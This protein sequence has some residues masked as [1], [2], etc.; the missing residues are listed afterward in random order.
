MIVNGAM[1]RKLSAWFVC[2][3]CT[4]RLLNPGT[5]SSYDNFKYRNAKYC[6]VFDISS[7][8][9]LVHEVVRR[10]TLIPGMVGLAPKWV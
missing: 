6:G 5:C 7:N 1:T 8:S 4:E 10:G 9:P 2:F 3:S